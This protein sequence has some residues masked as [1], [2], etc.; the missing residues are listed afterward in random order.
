VL[1]NI[2][3]ILVGTDYYF[4]LGS[5]DRNIPITI[6]MGQ[7]TYDISFTV[8]NDTI[9][10]P[11]ETFVLQILVSQALRNVALAG[12]STIVTLQDSDSF[13]K[14]LFIYIFIFTVPNV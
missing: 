6:P 14:Y 13:G 1:L 3:I 4:T 8:L 10:E 11:D 7:T 2:F 12:G 9:V 5:T